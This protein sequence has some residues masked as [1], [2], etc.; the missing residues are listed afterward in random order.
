MS[1]LY[2]ALSKYDKSIEKSGERIP[3]EM[4][5]TISGRQYT[6][7]PNRGHFVYVRLR[8]NLSEVIQAYND[9]VFPGYGIPVIVKWKN[10][11]YEV[12]ERDSQRYPEWEAGNP[13]IARHGDTHSMDKDGNRL[14]T[15]PVWVYPYQ[16]MPSLVSPFNANGVFNVYIH[17]FSL[18]Y[19]GEW[20]FTGNTG[21]SS[22][23]PYRPTSGSCVILVSIDVVSGN[24][25]LVSSTG[26]YVPTTATGT[27]QLI[28]Y[29][30]NVDR[31]RYIPLS[32]IRVESG[33][34]SIGWE[35]IY[36]VRQFVSYIP[37]L[38][39]NSTTEISNLQFS[40]LTVVSTG[41]VAFVSSSGGGGTTGG[42]GVYTF[43]IAGTL[44]TG[45]SSSQP[46]LVTDPATISKAYLYCETKGITGSTIIDVLKNGVS[47]FTGSPL[48]L[49]FN[50]TGT[51][52]SLIPYYSNFVQ[53]DII[54]TNVQQKAT[55]A[56]N[57]KVVLSAG[58]QIGSGLSLSDGSQSL[59]GI[60]SLLLSGLL[61]S[62]LGGNS[63]KIGTDYILIEDRKSSGT[64]GGTFNN[65]AWRTRDLTTEVYDTGNHASLSSNQITLEAGTYRFRISAPAFAVNN[66]QA[67]LYNISNSTDIKIGTSS[68]S[69]STNFVSSR[70]EVC[71]EFT[72]SVSTLLEVRHRCGT[73]K[74]TNGFGEKA[75][76]GET[77]IYTTVEFW[78][79]A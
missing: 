9:K 75:N 64:D 50:S 21:T 42:Y 29:L 54:T 48:T 63:A 47:I 44:E 19:G 20:K 49:P 35:N 24:P 76:F 30:P 4:G 74:A 56:G 70:S 53:G 59:S 68:Y 7:V 72:I 43:D 3:G 26:T 34:S 18:N 62:N 60:Q 71:G 73:S 61:L 1:D 31:S 37:T 67:K 33:T 51:W 40:G 27:P 16:F 78:K 52:V 66:H 10:S 55:G 14:G 79:V 17:P 41:T 11:R 32:V 39:V 28:S 22:F 8:S 12:I 45:T 23:A 5:I 15:D 69:G 6:E 58:L 57:A 46:W 77:E 36:D 2:N 38:Q 25:Y 13:Y 65:G